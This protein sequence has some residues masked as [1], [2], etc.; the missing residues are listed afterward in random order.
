MLLLFF[1]SSRIHSSLSALFFSSSINR[2]LIVYIYIASTPVLALIISLGLSLLPFAFHAEPLAA[3]VAMPCSIAVPVVSLLDS[4]G[5]KK[6][7]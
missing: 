1:S 2:K 6:S 4:H 7:V 3:L 5:Q